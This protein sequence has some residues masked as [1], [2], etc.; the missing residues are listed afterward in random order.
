M[1]RIREML[2]RLAPWN[3]KK[4]EQMTQRDQID[5]LREVMIGHKRIPTREG[6]V[7]IVVRELS[8]RLAEWGNK[9][10]V[11]NRWDLFT[12]G[13]KIGK[14]NYH[15]VRIR[16]I[17]T[18]HN[19]KLNAFLYSV[20]ASLRVLW[21]NYGVI[22]YHAIGSC[23]MMWI[24]AFFGKRTIVTVHGLDWQRAKWSRFASMYL[25]LGEWMAVHCADEMIVLSRG[26]Q[27]YFKEKYGRSTHL[28]PNGLEKHDPQ[29]AEII[30]SKYGVGKND[31]VLYLARIVPE[32]GL[33]YLLNAFLQVDTD[34]RLIIAGGLDFEDEYC[35]KIMEMAKRDKRVA[36]AGLVQGHEWEE[37]FSN[38][39]LYVLPSDIEGMPMS[40][41][42]AISFGK[43]CLASDI[44]ENVEAGKGTIT[45]F[46]QGDVEDL[47]EKIQYLLDHPDEG[48]SDTKEIVWENWDSVAQKTLELYLHV[49]DPGYR[50]TFHR[51][52]RAFRAQKL[53][54]PK[55]MK[56]AKSDGG[57]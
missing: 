36:L 21:G 37:L 48:F 39:S 10:E 52:L 15:G 43:R 34:K 4:A 24:P 22:H 2:S 56:G 38:C 5:Q 33:H 17:P 42:E 44:E 41:L 25:M 35:Q 16:Q 20:L 23:A 6:G 26:N 13:G 47:C 1:Q 19:S 45:H 46:R 18:L 29:G 27:R 30:T 9:V 55:S 28:I 14:R 11:Y 40:L 31:Y 12:K 32:K 50:P 53:R 54:K 49:L 3:W 51:E 8:V 57:K 7:E